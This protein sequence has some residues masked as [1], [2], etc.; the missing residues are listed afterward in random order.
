[1]EQQTIGFLGHLEF[2]LLSDDRARWKTIGWIIIVVGVCGSIDLA[3]LGAPIDDAVPLMGIVALIMSIGSVAWYCSIRPN[4][5]PGPLPSRRSL[6]L[7]AIGS[8]AALLIGVSLFRFQAR[9]LDSALLQA[10]K[11]NDYESTA[12]VFQRAMAASIHLDG[13]LVKKTSQRL[14]TATENPAAWDA[15]VASVDYSSF[16][17]ASKAPTERKATYIL[18]PAGVSRLDWTAKGPG[19]ETQWA[20]NVHVIGNHYLLLSTDIVTSDRAA[21]FEMIDSAENA[22]QTSGNEALIVD[23]MNQATILLDDTRIKNAVIRNAT[24]GY[25]GGRADLENVY[26][27]K[28]EFRL[29]Q[30]Q[31]GRELASKLLDSPTVTFKAN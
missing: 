1:M 8:A 4:R 5:N 30:K 22:A 6:A 16:L 10:T 18:I 7:Q 24:I 19:P 14:L 15:A 29:S 11:T 3:L 17:N 21:R 12:H 23:G 20:F 26:F 28:C 13:T 2:F 31:N 25:D 9:A 27:V